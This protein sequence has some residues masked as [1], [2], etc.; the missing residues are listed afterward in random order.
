[1]TSRIS[2]GFHQISV[3]FAV[4]PFAVAAVLAVRPRR[5]AGS[6]PLSLS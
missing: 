5:G 1:M 6:P 4:L 3:I 2:R